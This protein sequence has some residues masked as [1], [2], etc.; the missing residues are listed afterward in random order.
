MAQTNKESFV[1]HKD[2]FAAIN[3]L[4]TEKRLI[5][6]EG[7][8][9]FAITRYTLPELEK[10]PLF[11]IIKEQLK[12]DCDKYEQICEKRRKN[13]EERYKNKEKTTNVDTNVTTNVDTK[14]TN[15][16]TKYIYDTDTVTD[17]ET[18]TVS[19]DVNKENIKE[20]SA[21]KLAS[22]SLEERKE[23]FYNSLFPYLEQYGKEILREFYEYWTESNHNGNKLRWEMEKTFEISKRLATWKKNET[24]WNRQSNTQNKN[25][26]YTPEQCAAVKNILI[27]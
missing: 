18:G 15:V 24:K 4:P 16:T 20:N 22:L 25:A 26:Q 11:L 1:F 13:V 12:R 17:T 21:R 14:T 5:F 23:N 3:Q 10:D 8:A 2:W 19:K 6:Y 9:N 27:E 7:I